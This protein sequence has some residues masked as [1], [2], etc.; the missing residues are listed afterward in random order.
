M[1]KMACMCF[2]Q[3]G[4]ISTLK[5]GPLKFVNKFMYIGNSISSTESDVSMH[6]AQAWVTISQLSIIWKTDL[7]NKLKQNFIQE[8]VVSILL[9]GYT[10]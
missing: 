6:L 1:D 3:E 2:N 4:V 7:F 9:Y 5:G 10:R 8:A